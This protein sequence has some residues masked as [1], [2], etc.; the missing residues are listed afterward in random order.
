MLDSRTKA[1]GFYRGDAARL[2]SEAARLP[3]EPAQVP[4]Q[5]PIAEAAPA[6]VPTPAVTLDEPQ[7]PLLAPEPPTNQNIRAPRPDPIEFD[8]D[9]P[10]RWTTGR[11]VAW[12]L[13]APWYATIAVAAL[14]VDVLFVKDLFGL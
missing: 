6:V 4:E 12:I 11:I 9:E 1:T 10:A 13:L 8:D 3:A 2:V 5:Q 7:R 14:G